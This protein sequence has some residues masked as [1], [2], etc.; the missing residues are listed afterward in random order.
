MCRQHLDLRLA[1]ILR[2]RPVDPR[3]V[4][5]REDVWVDDEEPPGA[6]ANQ[7]LGNRGPGAAG[8]DEP[9]RQIADH[10]LH[11]RSK[12]PDVTVEQVRK[13][14]GLELFARFVLGDQSL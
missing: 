6:E 5:D 14:A 4:A 12:G 9:K 10:L 13:A 7:L 11:L 1:D 2:R 8:T 3:D